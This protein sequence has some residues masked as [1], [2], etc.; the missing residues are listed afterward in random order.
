MQFDVKRI[1]AG[2][3]LL[4]T[5]LSSSIL[6][7][8]LNSWLIVWLLLE[9]NTLSF[10]VIIKTIQTKEVKQ[11]AEIRL[12]YFVIQSVASA[13]LIFSCISWSA[14]TIANK[15][16][17]PLIILALIIKIAATPFHAWFISVIKK[18]N[19]KNNTILMTWQKLAPVYLIIFQPK[20]L[21][22]P[23]LLFSA[24]LGRLGQLNKIKITEIL[25]LSSIFNIRWIILSVFIRI[26]IFILFS[27]VYWR[28]VIFTVFLV[29]NS[30]IKTIHRNHNP[31]TKK[32]MY[33]IVIINLAGIP[34][35]AGFLA[36]W[37]VFITG[38]KNNFITLITILLV[39]RRINLFIYIRITNNIII[40]NHEK[41]Q[42]TPSTP[43]R[44]FIKAN[45]LT[46]ILIVPIIAIYRRR[47]PKG[48]F[49]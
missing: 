22:F 35:L 26:K 13:L 18:T 9:V 43:T 38:L 12:K 42:T 15:I 39:I 48:L 2:P 36:K 11:Q 31:A 23:F 17:V 33:L 27:L 14:D 25:A 49:W 46:N 45:I 16:F 7:L 40:E 32:W 37:I 3:I 8:F 1:S 29:S 41:I 19:W 34:P 6:C 47:L 30:K 5:L 10:C 44:T 4:S 24:L 21:I 20:L 28:R